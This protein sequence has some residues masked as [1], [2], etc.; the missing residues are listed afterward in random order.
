MPY[1]YRVCNDAARGADYR[2]ITD[3]DDVFCTGGIPIASVAVTSSYYNSRTCDFSA[4]SEKYQLR[5]T[6]AYGGDEALKKAATDA[7]QEA[8]KN[9]TRDPDGG[10]LP[11]AIV[12]VRCHYACRPVVFIPAKMKEGKAAE[13]SLVL[14][15]MN[16]SYPMF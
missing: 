14:S 15:G 9:A 12:D 11:S 16:L 7:T 2:H 5:Y 8:L 13:A 10:D 4:Y 6:S 1:T 3:N